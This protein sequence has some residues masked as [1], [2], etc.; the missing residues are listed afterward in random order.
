MKLISFFSHEGEGDLVSQRNR[1]WEIAGS[2]QEHGLHE[3]GVSRLRG[4]RPVRSPVE[5]AHGRRNLVQAP[6]PAPDRSF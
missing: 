4:E 1:V 2:L 3:A 6:P 5:D